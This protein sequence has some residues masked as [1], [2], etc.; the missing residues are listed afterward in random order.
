M[1][2]DPDIEAGGY[3]A[4][5]ALINSSPSHTFQI[6]RRFGSLNVRCLLYLQDEICELE[7]ALNEYDSHQE[8]STSRRHDQHPDRGNLIRHITGR[9]TEY[10]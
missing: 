7:A 10:S 9:L 8:K 4:L 3:P 6:F 2:T 5:A 1:P